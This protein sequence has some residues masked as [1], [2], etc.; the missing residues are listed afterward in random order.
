MQ[1][2]IGAKDQQIA[3]LQRYYVGYLANK[4]K[5]NGIIIISRNGEAPK[6]PYISVC[7]HHG[8]RNHKTR[9]LFACN[10]GSNLFADRD[11]PNSIV[12]YKFWQEDRLITVDQSI[13]YN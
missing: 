10:W 3:P 9:L 5:T 6:Y 1:N 2:E 11:M 8:C 12:K 7:R 13:D 4:D